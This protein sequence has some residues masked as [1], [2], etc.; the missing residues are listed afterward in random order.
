MTHSNHIRSS[1]ISHKDTLCGCC[2]RS[3]RYRCTQILTSARPDLSLSLSLSLSISLSLSLSLSPAFGFVSFLPNFDFPPFLYV[4]LQCVPSSAQAKYFSFFWDIHSYRC[5][6]ILISHQLRWA[7]K[8]STL[9]H[10]KMLSCSNRR[11]R[12]LFSFVRE[13]FACGPGSTSHR[14][15]PQSH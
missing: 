7:E 4:F 11:N 2:P 15:L 10:L 5:W 9:Q 3:H 14:F 8:C 1:E 6:S 13:S 12:H